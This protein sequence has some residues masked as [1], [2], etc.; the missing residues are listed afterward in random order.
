MPSWNRAIELSERVFRRLLRAYP[1]SLR[2]EYE[3]PM[4]QLFRDLCRDARNRRGG[5][6]LIA[7]WGFILRDTA[8]SLIREHVDEWRRI[9]DQFQR[10]LALKIRRETSPRALARGFLFGGAIFVLVGSVLKLTSLPLTEGQLLIGLLG[11]CGV[12]IQLTILGN[13]VTPPPVGPSLR[14]FEG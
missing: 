2:A 14:R 3:G 6:G 1:A 5:V 11:A 4:V 10:A 13:L 9:M 8:G 12:S 7:L